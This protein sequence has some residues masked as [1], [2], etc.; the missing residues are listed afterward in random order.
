MG[1]KS[2]TDVIR[3]IKTLLEK[4]GEL[5]V[6]QISLRL[7]SQWRTIDK[8]IDTMKL[9]GYVKE[10]MNKNTKRLERLISLKK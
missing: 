7:K 4:E 2:I 10:R 9:L 3:E 1:R 6:R 5:S 8:A